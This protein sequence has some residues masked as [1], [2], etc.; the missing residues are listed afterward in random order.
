MQLDFN[1]F[2]LTLLISGL[3]VAILSSVIIYRLNDY[4]RWFAITMLSVALWS[5][6]YGFELASIRLEDM[7]FWIK[8]EYLGIAFAPGLWLWFCIKYVGLER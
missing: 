1:I 5:I 4:V 3:L 6:A 7:L 2:S 8:I